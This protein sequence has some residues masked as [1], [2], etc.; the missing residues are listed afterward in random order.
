MQVT[1]F[2]DTPEL[3]L[4]PAALSLTGSQSPPSASSTSGLIDPGARKRLLRHLEA[5]AAELDLDFGHAAAKMAA[6]G[7]PGSSQM[8]AHLAAITASMA[9]PPS[10]PG[11]M[12]ACMDDR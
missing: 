4:G 6:Q 10:S 5:C 2:L 1:R 3:L 12:D 11:G 9:S 7:G 8:A